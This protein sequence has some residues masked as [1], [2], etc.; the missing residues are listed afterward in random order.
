M[1][2]LSRFFSLPLFAFI[3]PWCLPGVTF[4]QRECTAG[5][6][7]TETVAED[8]CWIE[9]E[10]PNQCDCGCLLQI[11]YPNSEQAEITP[12]GFLTIRV[13]GGIPPFSWAVTGDDGWT[14]DYDVTDTSYNIL[15]LTNGLG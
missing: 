1:R 4:A 8:S 12:G 11:T 15:R 3:L 5:P 6:T 13:R 2:K 10:E 9:C 14:L 7:I